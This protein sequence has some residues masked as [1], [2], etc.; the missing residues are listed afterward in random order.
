[1]MYSNPAWQSMRDRAT[2]MRFA[3]DRFD[4]EQRV[5]FALTLITLETL[6]DRALS[7]ARQL[8]GQPVVVTEAHKFITHVW[9]H[10]GRD[11]TL[12]LAAEDWDR[13]KA[14]ADAIRLIVALPAITATPTELRDWEE[15]R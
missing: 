13:A 3:Y 6:T 12:A 14:C 5:N 11:W 8:I 15:S 2:L 7:V 4:H 9:N 10:L 1:M